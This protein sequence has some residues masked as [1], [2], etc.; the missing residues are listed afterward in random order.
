MKFNLGHLV[1]CLVPDETTFN[2][3]T[4]NAS[5]AAARN[6]RA[7]RDSEPTMKR[8]PRNPNTISVIAITLY[9]TFTVDRKS[10]FVYY[11]EILVTYC[12]DFNEFLGACKALWAAYHVI[13]CRQRIFSRE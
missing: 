10:L 8:S 9:E 13:F 4:S 5:S 7:A 12:S 6:D 3:E 11:K 2:A 1:A